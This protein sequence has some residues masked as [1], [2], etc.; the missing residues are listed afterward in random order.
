MRRCNARNGDRLC[1]GEIETGQYLD[2]MAPAEAPRRQFALPAAALAIAAAILAAA[3]A[4]LSSPA[5][6]RPADADLSARLAELAGPALRAAPAGRQDRALGLPSQ[7]PGSLLREGGRV[8]VDVRFDR[9]A[10]ALDALRAAGARI[11]QVSRRYRTVTVAAR[12][13]AMPALAS[14]AGVGGVTEVLTP[15][16]SATC[17]GLV[18]SEGDAQL[19]AAAAR[20]DFNLDG[21]GVTVGILSDS[22]D[23]DA[24][25]LTRAAGDVSSGDLPGAG[26]P[27]GYAGSVGRLDDSYLAGEPA[28]TDQGR[29]MAQTIHD[30]APAAS[31]A[32]ATA[33]EGELSFAANI[34][35]L[36]SAGARVI[37]DD[38]TYLEEPFFQDGP[39]AAAVDEVAA[40]GVAYFAAA[41]N[42]NLIDAGHDIASWEAP[43]FRDT[44]AQSS[45]E[46]CPLGLPAYATH[47]MDFD[48]SAGATDPTFG[49]TV[50][51]GATLR[52]DLQ[53]QQP[54][55]GVTTDLDPYLLS[56]STVLAPAAGQELRNVTVSKKPV[57]ILT[58]TNEG[59]SAQAVELAIDRCGVGCDGSNGNNGSPRLKF[60]LVQD[61]E[62]VTETEYSQSSG[63]DVV[64]PTI[65]GHGAAQGAVS[66]G[67][68]SYED[69]QQA[70]PYSS[71]GPVTHYFGPATGLAPAAALPG[72]EA[73]SK[74]DIAATDCGLTTFLDSPLAP[75]A[76]TGIHRFCGTS[77][78]AAHAAGVAAL[79][80]QANPSLSLSQLRTALATT[81]RPVGAFGADA[82]G[83][84]LINAQGAVGRVALPPSVRITQAPA[85]VSKN[86]LPSFGF[87]ASRPVVFSCTL[88]GSPLFLCTAPF[89]PSTP[90][91]DGEHGFAV[92]G[93]DAAGRIGA[94]ETVLFTVDTKRPN[95]FLRVRPRKTVRTRTRRARVVFAF[96]S[97]EADADFVC[98]TN[99]GLFR[100]CQPRQVMRLGAG[101]HTIRVKAVDLAG[102]ADAS[103]AVY[104]FRIKRVG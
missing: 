25:A 97:N 99:R 103:P 23:T 46:T 84:G 61:G 44:S 93:V 16:T 77:A 4:P 67:A 5:A 71:R 94:S 95:T 38:V 24:G 66:V 39:V 87:T 33:L 9:G 20:T 35:A 100:F 7:G 83:A 54:W 26:N 85:P 29:A 104:R 68:V 75:P 13:A 31:L 55:Y 43:A 14:I 81:A 56:G 63:G 18:T 3:W 98:R 8:I 101:E 86:R 11:V 42:N 82:V 62:G 15:L 34:R 2:S 45:P 59:P 70:E 36:A 52:V 27:C 40:G 53:W 74:P 88:D 17:A 79:M 49:I 19:R 22:F 90:L 102:N 50:A 60:V 80:R 12:P 6:G 21:A 37:V 10:P 58:W 73:I 69:P 92:E 76:V 32:F 64:G 57:E 1:L 65:F 48:P 89:V 30:L 28:P 47:C 96:R 78:A 51:A 41:G 72:P 91:S